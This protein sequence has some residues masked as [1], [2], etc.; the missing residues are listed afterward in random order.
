MNFKDVPFEL[1]EIKRYSDDTIILDPHKS[2]S[3]DSIEALGE[4]NKAISAVA[5]G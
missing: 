5:A 3:E 2:T 4:T 1:W